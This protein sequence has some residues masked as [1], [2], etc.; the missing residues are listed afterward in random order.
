MAVERQLRG[1]ETA[2]VDT[3]DFTRR[4]AGR[5]R[6]GVNRR[7]EAEGAR[8]NQ[9][10]ACSRDLNR[11]RPARRFERD[12]AAGIGDRDGG[13]SQDR[14]SHRYARIREIIYVVDAQRDSRPVA[15]DQRQLCVVRTAEYLDARDGGVV[16][17][18]G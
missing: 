13:S 14:R 17:G 12:T 7:G 16:S 2:A 9:R 11:Y 3:R 10:S 15:S 5:T 18:I 8:D 4:K 6:G 1:G